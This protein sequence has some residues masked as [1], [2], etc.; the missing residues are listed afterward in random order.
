MSEHGSEVSAGKRFEFGKNWQ[1][2]LSILDETK[3][4][5]A[6]ESLRRMLDVENLEGKCFLDIGSG[7]GLFSLSARSL[8]ATVYSFDYDPLSVACTRELKARFFP[9]DDQWTITEGSV[10]EEQ[11]MEQL[12]QFDVVYSWGVLHHTGEMWRAIDIAA[13]RV[14]EGAYFFIMIYLDTGL[15]SAIW[16]WIKRLYCSSVVGKALV[17]SLF[18]PYYLVRGFVEDVIRLK[19]PFRRYKERQKARGMSAFRDWFD[20][21]GGFPYEYAKPEEVEEFCQQR[22]LTLLKREGPEYVFRKTE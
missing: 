6:R 15:R 19:S 22:N 20:W 12:G 9:E 14:R 16:W 21:L 10:L 17:L 13:R 7:S 2:Y 1:R 18:L 4:A 3:M 11:F 5:T 8:G